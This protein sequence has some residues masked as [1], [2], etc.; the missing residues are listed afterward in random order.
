MAE[1]TSTQIEKLL[2]SPDFTL[3]S[4][5]SYEGR[6]LRLYCKQYENGAEANSSTI[7]WMVRAEGGVVNWYGTGPTTVMV[8]STAV[9]NNYGRVSPSA[10]FPAGR[11]TYKSGSFTVNHKSDGT[12]DPLPMSISTAIYWGAW[13][14]Q[15]TDAVSWSLRKID[16]YFSKSPEVQIST[17]RETSIIVT[18]TTSETAST[19]NVTEKNGK[20]FSYSVDATNKRITFSNLA[21]GTKY[22]FKISFTRADSGMI[23]TVEISPSTYHHPYIQRITRSVVYPGETVKAVIY[24]PRQ[25]SVT[26][27]MGIVNNDTSSGSV[28]T[29]KTTTAHNTEVLLEPTAANIYAKLPIATSA[30]VY[31]YCKTSN[32]DNSQQTCSGKISIKGTEIP[33]L[34]SSYNWIDS[35]GAAN[36]TGQGST[37]STT[38]WMVQNRS[39]LTTRMPIGAT[40]ATG[41]TIKSYT[42]KLGTIEKTILASDSAGTYQIN[43]GKLNLVGA[44]DFTI[45]VTDQRGLTNSVTKQI[46]FYPY[47][48]PSA[49][50][51]A[52][53]RNNYGTTVDLKY[54]YEYSDVN[55]KNAI[56]LYYIMEQNGHTWTTYLYGGSSSGS[57]TVEKPPAEKATGTKTVTG[58]SND[59]GATFS[60][61]IRD[62]FGNVILA[63]TSKIER[64]QPIFF[65][66]EEQNGVGVGCFP[67]GDGLH[68]S[69]FSIGGRIEIVY[70]ETLNAIVFRSI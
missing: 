62:L 58:L 12:I 27:Y 19:I 37:W 25:L 29:S 30:K 18:Y 8:G 16:R 70:D 7:H 39:E 14:T 21:P 46:T 22:I 26:I 4:K 10:V 44:Q 9:L 67:S 20:S 31:Y 13:N 68:A 1:L 34:P 51:E 42:F 43:W 40:A 32:G 53:R 36:V 55:G 63:D 24:N 3:T 5:A 33:G 23:S 57:P 56:Q 17:T 47:K 38:N 60:I 28:I 49:S 61:Y 41:T 66:D 45:T 6:V 52:V 59:Y 11:N 48:Q 65:I 69:K 50:I 15:T 54:G 35:S 2:N 64:G